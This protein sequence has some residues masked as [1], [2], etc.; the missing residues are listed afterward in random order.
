MAY[1]QANKPP[2]EFEWNVR[3]ME[4]G[5]PFGGAVVWTR[6]ASNEINYWKDGKIVTINP[7]GKKCP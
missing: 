4:N 5:R 3:V 2:S 1:V 7:G 6:C